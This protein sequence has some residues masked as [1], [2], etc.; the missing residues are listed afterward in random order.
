MRTCDTEAG[1]RTRIAVHV[2][3]FCSE[4]HSP[5]SRAP[6]SIVPRLLCALTERAV[7]R[8]ERLLIPTSCLELLQKIHI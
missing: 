6:V 4:L 8:E 3:T 1:S 2:Q 5:S 7:H